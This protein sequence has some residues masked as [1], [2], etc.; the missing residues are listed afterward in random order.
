M[1]NPPDQL[2]SY[3]DRIQFLSDSTDP[4]P[5]LAHSY[6]RYLGDLSGGQFIRRTIAKAYEL[7]DTSG[8]G[9]EFY[10]FKQLGSSKKATQG[11]MKTIKEW[12]R[13][14]MNKSKSEETKG[15]FPSNESNYVIC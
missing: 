4:S 10:A 8:L 12:F 15:M 5:L 6:A 2:R 3:V 9:T 1:S 7:G 14:G 13:D 11:D